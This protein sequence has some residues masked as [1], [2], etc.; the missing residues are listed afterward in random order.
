MISVLSSSVGA[1][2]GKSGWKGSVSHL[3]CDQGSV[4]GSPCH[5]GYNVCRPTPALSQLPSLPAGSQQDVPRARVVSCKTKGNTVLGGATRRHRSHHSRQD[6]NPK[7]SQCRGH[8]TWGRAVGPVGRQAEIL[9]SHSTVVSPRGLDAR[10]QPVGK[11]HPRQTLVAGPRGATSG[12]EIRRGNLS[13]LPS[14]PPSFPLATVQ[15]SAAATTAR[16]GPGLQ[17]QPQ[18]VELGVWER[19]MGVDRGDAGEREGGRC[20]QEELHWR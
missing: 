5:H 9:Y 3:A 20:C 15:P 12:T 14:P 1:I 18:P 11:T 7:T 10:M 17:G 13:P 8:Q 4:T 2:G 16:P 6:P 19:G